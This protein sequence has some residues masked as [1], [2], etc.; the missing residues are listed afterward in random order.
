MYFQLLRYQIRVRV[1]NGK[2]HDNS[3]RKGNSEGKGKGKGKDKDKGMIHMHC[4]ISRFSLA[5][6]V[7]MEIKILFLIN[8]NRSDN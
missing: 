4:V 1:I 7:L 8:A 5:R 6:L 2:G 3:N